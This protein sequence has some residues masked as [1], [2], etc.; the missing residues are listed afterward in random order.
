[1]S[2]LLTT[3]TLIY[4]AY[5][6]FGLLGVLLFSCLLGA[7]SC[8]LMRMLRRT[9]N[10]MACLFYA[11]FAVYLM[12]SFFTTWYSNPTT[13]FYLAVTGAAAFA[14]SRRWGE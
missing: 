11:Q 1:M 2:A 13:W 8:L 3:L 9:A 5:Y 10:P 6:D 7:V 14:V 12:L 4:D